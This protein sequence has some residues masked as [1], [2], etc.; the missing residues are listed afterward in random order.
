MF[1]KIGQYAN[2]NNHFLKKL[3]LFKK[4]KSLNKILENFYEN[5]N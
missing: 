4:L 3:D 5:Y 2:Q 1:L